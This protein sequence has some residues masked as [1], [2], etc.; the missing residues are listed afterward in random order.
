MKI[1]NMMSSGTET[2]RADGHFFHRQFF[3]SRQLVV[4]GYNHISEY[5]WTTRAQIIEMYLSKKP[6]KIQN[7][8]NEKYNIVFLSNTFER[9]RT[10]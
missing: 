6:Q 4:V 2:W 8:I 3:V 10:I 9:D 1:T 5:Y 7:N